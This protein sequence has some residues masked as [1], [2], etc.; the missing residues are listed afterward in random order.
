MAAVIDSSVLALSAKITS[1][2]RIKYPFNYRL[3]SITREYYDPPKVE[4]TLLWIFGA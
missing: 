2:G 3:L 4:K 1:I